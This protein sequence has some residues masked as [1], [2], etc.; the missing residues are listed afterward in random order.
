MVENVVLEVV[1]RKEVPGW[2]EARRRGVLGSV[3]SNP[4]EARDKSC[5]RASFLPLSLFFGERNKEIEQ[6][7]GGRA[8]SSI[9]IC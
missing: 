9:G 4:V 2:S 8:K 3:P 7:V 6:S 1:I 5:S